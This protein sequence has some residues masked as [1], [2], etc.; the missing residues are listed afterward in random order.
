MTDTQGS[1]LSLRCVAALALALP[2]W[3]NAASDL[4][5]PLPYDSGIPAPADH[6]FRGHIDLAVDA[7][8]TLQ[9]IFRVHEVIPVQASGAITLLYAEWEVSSH[10]RTVSAAN[11]AGLTIHAD[12][13]ALPWTRDPVDMHAFHIDAPAG[14]TSIEVDLQYITRVDD[15]L[16]QDRFVN[17]SWQHLL[18]YPAGWFARNIPVEASL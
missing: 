4:P 11:L 10:S 6:P 1:R 14:A 18:V 15:S 17:V 8:D 13:K 3:V 7:T 5:A 9:K 12:G 2:A 16:I